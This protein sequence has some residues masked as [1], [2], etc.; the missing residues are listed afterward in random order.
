MPGTILVR[1]TLRRV[2]TLLQDISPQFIN[3]PEREAVDALNDAH[4]AIAKFLPGAS[5]RNDAVRLKPGTLQSIE[6]IAPAY[7]KPGDGST[8]VDPIMGVNFL[9]INRNMGA[10]GLTP[11]RIV[12]VVD[13]D[14]LDLQDEDWHLPSRAKTAVQCFTFDPRLPMYF[15]VSPPVHA[16][17]Q[18]WVQLQ[19]NAQP[20][21]IPNTGAP[22]SE[23]YLASGSNA[24]T[25]KI[26]DEF[27]DDLVNYV[28]ARANMK[29]AEWADGN[30]ATYFTNLFL[31]SLNAKVT[32]NTGT[33]PNL[34]RLPLAPEPV[35]QAS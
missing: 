32:A 2:S 11:G 24:E 18:V 26:R 33:N 31:G 34:K 10:D 12:R 28:V 4:L 14:I 9:G 3:Y 19:F 1:E 29:D 27:I 21:R 8:P 30:K 13:Q 15:S 25:I 7:C 16:S 23:I 22:G 35:A 20:L 5:S 6:S 17:T